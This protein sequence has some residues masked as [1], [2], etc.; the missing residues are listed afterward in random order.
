[1]TGIVTWS[2][3]GKKSLINLNH[4][5]SHVM[6]ECVLFILQACLFIVWGDNT[7]VTMLWQWWPKIMVSST[8]KA[9]D[10]FSPV[11]HPY[12]LPSF[13]P[14]SFLPLPPFL[15]PPPLSPLL[16]PLSFPSLSSSLPLPLFSFSPYPLS[17]LSLSL[18]F[19][20]SHRVKYSAL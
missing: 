18:F 11:F 13:P 7:H 4:C 8:G 19:L 9:L 14:S 1:M 12:S 3:V 20:F 15:S 10:S 17:L 6:T 2:M 16:L 5:L